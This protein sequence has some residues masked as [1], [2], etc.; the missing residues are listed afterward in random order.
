MDKVPSNITS[1][2]QVSG[3]SQLYP[4]DRR[5]VENHFDH[6]LKVERMEQYEFKQETVAIENMN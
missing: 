1:S 4:E 3:M 5:E 2:R 6:E